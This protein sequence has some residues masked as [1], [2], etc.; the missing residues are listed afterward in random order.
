MK[1]P[2]ADNT[3][4]QT[5]PA[6]ITFVDFWVAAGSE[7]WFSTDA[8]F[9]TALRERFLPL[10]EAAANGELDDWMT[11]PTGSLALVLLLDQFPRNAFRGTPRM[12]MTDARARD[13][14]DIALT[15]N[16]DRDVAEELRVFFGLP[17]SHSENLDDQQ[18][19]RDLCQRLSA[20]GHAQRHFGIIARF[21]RFPH[22]NKILGRETTLEEQSYLDEGG[23]RG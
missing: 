16:H 2:Y 15:A 17:F 22:R 10:H 7:R 1:A 12:Y 3:I 21:G 13:V 4:A 19:A 11:S 9:D 23:F 6:A 20:S 5:P 8:D 14:A 18:R